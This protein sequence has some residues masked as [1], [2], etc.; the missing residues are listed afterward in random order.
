MEAPRWLRLFVRARASSLLLLAVMIGLLGGLVVATMGEAVGFLHRMFF[1]LQPGAFLSAQDALNPV[2]AVATPLLGGLAFG[3]ASALI[4]RRRPRREIDP[5]EANALHG[6]RMSLIGS[7]VVA[8]KTVWSSGVGASVGLEAGYTQL[9]SGIASRI[10]QS[11]RL[12]RSDLRI[13]VGCGAAAG[14]SGAFGSP[15]GGAFYAFE[16]VVGNY[17]VFSL[18][19]VTIAAVVGFLTVNALSPAHLVLVSPEER[20]GGHDLVISAVLGLLAAFF[21]IALMRGVPLCEA[22]FNRLKVRP[23][24]RPAIGGV[25]VGGL[26]IASP[27]VMS[28]GHGALHV[29][30]VLH[31]ALPVVATVLVMKAAAS[32]ISLGSGFRGGLFFASMLM[33]ALGGRLLATGLIALW[34][35]IGIDPGVY[36]VVGMSALSA[37]VIG[38]PM[39]MTF[40]ALESTGD[41]WLTTAVLIAVIVST[42]VTRDL[43][44]Y[45]FATWRF[46]LRGET[47]RS[48]A[49]IGRIRDLTVQRLMRQDV[50]TVPAEMTV[51]EFL[52]SFPPGST[53]QVAAVETDGRYAGMVIV[54]EANAVTFSNGDTVRDILRF[55]DDVLYPGMNVQEAVASFDRTEAEALAVIDSPASQKILG[56]LS[57]AY[58]L[59]RYSAELEQHRRELVGY[60]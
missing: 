7:F 31:A 21:G 10:G 22:V 6:G 8:A 56:L 59:R 18:A 52:H 9:A 30:G 14:I 27:Q 50:R 4:A 20:I 58:A 29:S 13:L 11:L 46:H 3:L 15:L 34:P 23:L 33:G 54:A 16:I 41:L 38:G 60:I 32:I 25:L 49:D 39:T 2:L 24:L 28:A 55:K 17:S 35:G 44:G 5:V 12:R 42:Q 45:S 36:A 19:P 43:F 53:G 57:E 40:I 37:S 1:H 47:I 26:A 51:E 48:A